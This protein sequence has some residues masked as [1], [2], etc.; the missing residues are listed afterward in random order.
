MDLDRNVM[1]VAGKTSTGRR[2]LEMTSESAVIL[3]RR[4]QTAQDQ[5]PDAGLFASPRIKGR[6]IV[7]VNGPHLQA[8]IEAPVS[9]VLY[10]LR[11]TFATRQL[12][13]VGTDIATIAALLGHSGLRVAARYIHPQPKTKAEAMKKYD[14]MLRT[15]LKAVK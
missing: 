4:L 9:F 6:H 11:H 15:A 7:K 1:R 8:C 2:E 5:G 10:D 14:K 12:T 3:R 13:E